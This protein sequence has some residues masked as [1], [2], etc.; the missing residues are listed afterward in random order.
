MASTFMR[1]DIAPVSS[2]DDLFEVQR[3][4]IAEQMDALP[5]VTGGRY[6][7]L[8]TWEN[9]ANLQDLLTSSPNIIPHNQSA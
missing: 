5:V 3:R 1:H 8:V 9:I 6:L 7:G 4:L 2:D